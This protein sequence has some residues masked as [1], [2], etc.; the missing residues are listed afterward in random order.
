MS[1]RCGLSTDQIR[2]RLAGSQLYGKFECGAITPAAFAQAVT[3]E[4][5]F[6]GN[7]V[8]FCEIWT[9]V[10][11]PDPLLPESLIT[12]LRRDYR[13]LIVS[14]TNEIHFEM[15]RKTYGIIEQ[16]DDYVLSYQVGAMKP[17]AAFYQAAI[18]S[19]GCAP[20]RCIFIDDLP[21]TVEGARV[22]GMDGILFLGREQLEAELKT[23]SVL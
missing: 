1:L 5:N 15:L 20:E 9:S 2:G 18:A 16:F 6:E 7:F 13:T 14:N 10:F 4:L 19:A 3:E 12:K 21:E 17:N 11:L 8:E 23:R 22:A